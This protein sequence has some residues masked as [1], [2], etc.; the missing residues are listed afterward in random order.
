MIKFIFTLIFS[1]IGHIQI[2]CNTYYKNIFL[3]Q[4]QQRIFMRNQNILR[5]RDIHKSFGNTHV[6]K[7]IDLEAGRHEVI[8]IIGS[9]GSGKST[10]LRCLNFLE[11][12]DR[13]QVIIGGTEVEVKNRNGRPVAADRSQIEQLRT[14]VGMGLS[15]F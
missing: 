14:R 13:G 4:N 6:L 15:G 9:S 1:F 2:N 8:S 11:V 12:P 7:G 3:K 5:A 10:F